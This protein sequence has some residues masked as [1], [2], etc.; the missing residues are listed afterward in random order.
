MPSS[1]ESKKPRGEHFVEH[2]PPV[3]VGP[4]LGGERGGADA[5]EPGASGAAGRG[6]RAGGAAR[7]R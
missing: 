5:R 2:S 4:S 3:P 1:L 7:T 6:G